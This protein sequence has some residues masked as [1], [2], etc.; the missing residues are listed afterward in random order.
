MLT[1]V[2]LPQHS[3]AQHRAAHAYQSKIC[4]TLWPR[5]MHPMQTTC[6]YAQSS[7][8]WGDHICCAVGEGAAAAPT[9]TAPHI[10]L[11]KCS[12]L[13]ACKGL[14]SCCTLAAVPALQRHTAGQLARQGPAPDLTENTPSPGS[15][16]YRALCIMPHGRCCGS[17]CCMGST[18]QLPPLASNHPCL[19]TSTTQPSRISGRRVL[20]GS[21]C[22]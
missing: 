10:S 15:S 11:S 16:L 21:Q 2:Q 12:T 6:T 1:A 22:R 13:G 18:T 4:H 8:R 17:S 14:I 9:L 19:A 3:T 20:P 5:H 7:P